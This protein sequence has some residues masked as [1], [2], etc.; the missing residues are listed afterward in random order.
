MEGGDWTENLKLLMLLTYSHLG[1]HKV[2]NSAQVQA[3]QVGHMPQVSHRANS[4]LGCLLVLSLVLETRP[5]KTTDLM[6]AS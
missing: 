4:L 1:S 5:W 2:V 3:F 6:Q